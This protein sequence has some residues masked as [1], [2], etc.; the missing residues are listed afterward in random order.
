MPN[1]LAG[2]LN[3]FGPAQQQTEERLDL[4][5][6]G[7]N[8][9]RCSCESRSRKQGDR[10][11]YGAGR[12]GRD[13]GSAVNPLPI[14]PGS[15]LS[16]DHRCGA[17]PGT[18]RSCRARRPW[19]PARRPGRRLAA[20]R[21]IPARCGRLDRVPDGGAPAARASLDGPENDIMYSNSSGTWASRPASARPAGRRWRRRH[22]SRAPA[23]P[24]P[25]G[26]IR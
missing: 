11:G 21:R 12:T 9:G 26:A 19:C 6:S 3:A 13:Q 10:P 5:R 24:G 7:P 15:A 8:P 16:A 4:A 22:P 17:R 18:A 14:R 2:E 20:G 1:G 25:P 23:V